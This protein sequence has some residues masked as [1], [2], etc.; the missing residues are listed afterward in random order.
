[1]RLRLGGQGRRGRGGCGCI[2]IMPKCVHGENMLMCWMS[3]DEDFYLW[4]D[5]QMKKIYYLRGHSALSTYA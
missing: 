3:D 4:N 2:E 5:T 1:M